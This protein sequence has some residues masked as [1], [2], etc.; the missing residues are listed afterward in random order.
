MM[1]H[2]QLYPDQRAYERYNYETPILMLIK[3]FDFENNKEKYYYLTSQMYNYSREGIYFEIDYALKPGSTVFF[4]M[5]NLHADPNEP[6]LQ[7]GYHAEV[8]WC[9][10]TDNKQVSRYGLGVQY[11]ESSPTSAFGF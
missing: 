3:K 7:N 11:S 10:Q 8:R 9:K 6:S 1:Q 4:K 2:A 5:A